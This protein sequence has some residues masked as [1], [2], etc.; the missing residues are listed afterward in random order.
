MK[1]NATKQLNVV[2]NHVP[3]QVVSAGK[4]VVMIDSLVAVNLDKILCCCQLAVVVGCCNLYSL[5]L[6]KAARSI[7]NDC[8]YFRKNLSQAFL[9]FVENLLLNLVNL[10]KDW[11][12]V[13]EF[14]L[15]DL[16]LQFFNLGFLFFP[17]ILQ[18]CLKNLCLF[19]KFIVR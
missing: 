12:T 3:S 13:F 8:I 15:L 9:K 18:I 14:S 1:N 7:L 2:V 5:V 6:G 17:L 16:S 19:T 4:P 10:L 11:L